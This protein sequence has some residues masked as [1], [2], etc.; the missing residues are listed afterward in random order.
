MGTGCVC[1]FRNITRCVIFV[2]VGYCTIGFNGSQL[3]LLVIGVVGRTSV[4]H[5]GD[6]IPVV[7]V[8]VSVG[9]GR[10][11]IIV[12]LGNL[13]SCCI[14]RVSVPIIVF[15][16]VNAA[17][18]RTQP[19]QAVISIGQRVTNCRFVGSQQSGGLAVGV[20]FGIVGCSNSPLL[21]SELS[22]EVT[23]YRPRS[24][25]GRQGPFSLRIVRHWARFW[26]QLRPLSYSSLGFTQT[27]PCP[28]EQPCR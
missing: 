19:L 10:R 23:P 4:Y 14:I 1:S 9:N 21:T 6:D 24:A 2:L 22:A 5:V 25:R 13:S 17:G 27:V 7:I 15:L 26:T 11:K 3:I 16:I 20:G 12:Q 8:P 18:D 28:T